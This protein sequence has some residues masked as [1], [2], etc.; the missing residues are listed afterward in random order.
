MFGSYLVH[1]SEPNRS[2]LPRRA[3]LFSYQPSGREHMLESLRRLADRFGV[4]PAL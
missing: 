3:L 2:E 1:H 4:T